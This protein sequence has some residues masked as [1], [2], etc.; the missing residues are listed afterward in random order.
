MGNQIATSCV[1][2]VPNPHLP[3]LEPYGGA[4]L[5]HLDDV[6]GSG[7]SLSQRELNEI[8]AHAVPRPG[9]GGISANLNEVIARVAFS[10]SAVLT[11]AFCSIS[12]LCANLAR[13]RAVGM[14]ITGW[15]AV[16]L[17][18]LTSSL[19]GVGAAGAVDLGISGYNLYKETRK[20]EG[21][22]SAKQKYD[23]LF[24]KLVAAKK[25]RARSLQRY[26]D[27][28]NVWSQAK[29]NEER[30][31]AMWAR[32]PNMRRGAGETLL[33]R[34]AAQRRA[35]EAAYEDAKRAVCEARDALMG[36]EGLAKVGVGARAEVNMVKLRFSTVQSG[37]RNGGN[38]INSTMKLTAEI[39]RQTGVR[40]AAGKHLLSAVPL[41]GV[42]VTSVGVLS[43]LVNIAREIYEIEAL[44]SHRA[45]IEET[46]VALRNCSL[47]KS[48]REALDNVAHHAGTNLST[49]RK[50]SVLRI[51]GAALCIAADL[52]SFTGSL[53]AITGIGAPIGMTIST[54][55][56]AVCAGAAAFS[57]GAYGLYQ[58]YKNNQAMEAAGPDRFDITLNETID[59][60]SVANSQCTE[61]E[62]REMATKRLAKR[63]QYFA[64]INLI[65]AL[66]KMSMPSVADSERLDLDSAKGREFVRILKLAGVSEKDVER[67]YALARAEPEG[68]VGPGSASV[69]ALL[70]CFSR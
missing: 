48:L 15:S 63:N 28:V 42:I 64:A 20:T 23:A 52:L 38:F 17:G 47:N 70:D 13:Q 59:Q 11:G 3:I 27:S 58:R 4:P 61:K 56:V 34:A 49:E 41:V 19:V 60:L 6:E 25:E 14:M 55:G 7:D 21:Y 31:R 68:L 26:K 57:N 8:S 5:A 1:E 29:A 35:C 45:R 51:A 30:I 53:L 69:T 16:N 46:R 54:I 62:L 67:V 12:S 37:V 33:P 22:A 65:E 9:S 10:A 44:D 36:M 39:L 2:T 43:G 18:G 40:S 32:D 24:G 50:G 66:R